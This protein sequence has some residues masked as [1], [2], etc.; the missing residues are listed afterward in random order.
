[1]LRQGT[2]AFINEA[3]HRMFGGDYVRLTGQAFSQLVHPD[4][5]DAIGDDL[6][7]LVGASS[8]E[9]GPVLI[10]I[11]NDSGESLDCEVRVWPFGSKGDGAVAVELRNVTRRIRAAAAVRQSEERLGSIVDAVTDAVV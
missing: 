11:V 10:K 2:I 9:S 6:S 8:T 4:Y 3:G 5:R 7:N 1:M